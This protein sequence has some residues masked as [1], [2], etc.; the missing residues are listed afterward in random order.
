MSLTN[1]IRKAVMAL[2]V[3]CERMQAGQRGKMHF[4]TAGAADLV[5]PLGLLEVKRPDKADKPKPHQLRWHE[6]WRF[7]GARVEVVRSVAEALLVIRAWRDELLFERAMGWDA[8]RQS[9]Q[10]PAST[11]T[12][13]S[14]ERK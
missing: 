3:P 2:G 4:A 8:A 10:D 11:R 12:T 9:P 5:T 6:D 13:S 1:D 14:P 7:W